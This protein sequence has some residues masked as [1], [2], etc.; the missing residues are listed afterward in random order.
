MGW[1]FVL[2]ILVLAIFSRGFRLFLL[3]SAVAVG[4]GAWIWH[5]STQQRKVRAPPP[6]VPISDVVL[7]HA[8][9]GG[10]GRVRELHGRLHNRNRSHSLLAVDVLVTLRDCATGPVPTCVVI[11]ERRESLPVRV[12]P[13]QARDVT[14]L[15]DFAN[16]TVR[17][18]MS[19]TYAIV[20]VLAE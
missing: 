18:E 10:S 3:W 13:G 5:A 7:E 12:P 1:L 9:L 20:G 8:T 15:V 14:E 6:H 17:G 11:G 4:I 16:A 2:G 19:W